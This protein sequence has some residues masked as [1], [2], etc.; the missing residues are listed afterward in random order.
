MVYDEKSG[1]ITLTY[2]CARDEW[3]ENGCSATTTKLKRFYE[4][5]GYDP[6]KVHVNC[7]PG[8]GYRRGKGGGTKYITKYVCSDGS[9]KKTKAA[10]GKKKPR[11]AGKAKTKTPSRAFSIPSG[12]GGAVFDPN[13][14]AA[15]RTAT[16]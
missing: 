15:D 11:V 6:H 5:S 3:D 12:A 16:Y 14:G 9:V 13:V 2:Q 8:R 1:V 4:D 7:S 10:C